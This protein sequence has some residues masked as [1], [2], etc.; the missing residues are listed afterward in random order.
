MAMRRMF[1]KDVVSKRNFLEM[2]PSS[3]ALYYQLG[4]E[5][6]DDGFIDPY[7]TMLATKAQEDDLKI[8]M[9]K[10]FVIPFESGVLVI[11]HWNQHNYIRKDTYNE[12]QYKEEKRLLLLGENGEYLPSPSTSRQRPV[13]TG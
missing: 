3:R 4:V 5:A 2:P 7:V 12:T 6:D 11:T 1:T 13:N 10:G 8:L 9:A